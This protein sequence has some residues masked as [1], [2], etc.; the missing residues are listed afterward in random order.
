MS[1]TNKRIYRFGDFELKPSSRTLV[2]K[3]RPVPL[4]SKA[5]EVLVCLVVHHGDVVTKDQML[6][7]VWPNSFVD[8]GNLSQ[9]I[10][11]LR[12]ALA[13]SAGY[14]VT[15]PGRGYQF[16]AAVNEV[17]PE[18]ASAGIPSTSP[19]QDAFVVQTTRERAHLVM[20]ESD[21]EI[22]PP[23]PR[24]FLPGAARTSRKWLVMLGA[25]AVAAAAAIGLIAWHRASNVHPQSKSIVLADFGNRTGDGSFDAVL[26]QALQ[27]DLDQSP[28]LN[29]MSESGA[30]ATLQRMDRRPDTAFTPAVAREVCERSNRQAFVTSSIAQIG[31]HYLLTLEATDCITGNVL[32]AAKSEAPGKNDILAALDTAANTLRRGLGESTQSMER[33]QVPVAQATTSS[34]EAL[35]AYSTGEYLLGRMGEEQSETLPLF[36]QAVQ[37]D[38]NFAMAQMAVATAYNAMGETA[39]ASPYYQKAFDLSGH[40]SEKEKLYIQAHYYADDLQDLDKGIRGYQLWAT[41]YPGDWGP[42]LNIAILEGEL[43]Q[44]V[45]AVEAAE[46]ALQLDGTRGIIYSTLARAYMR[47][48]RFDDA[49]SIAERALALGKDS[50]GIHFILFEIGFLA[51]DE[52]G[53][54]RE[55]QWSEGKQVEP[56]FLTVQAL[57]SASRG[58][59]KD[60]EDLF[61]RAVTEA[62]TQHM[63]EVAERIRM[64]EAATELAL[65]ER[66]MAR[67]TLDQ[68]SEHGRVDPRFLPLQAMLGDP[69]TA[70]RLLST[71]GSVPH[72]S[73]LL[74]HVYLPQLRAVVAAQH[75]M[76]NEAIVSLNPATPYELAVDFGVITQRAEAYS[77]AAQPKN[78]AAQYRNILAHQ[79]VDAI[80]PLYPLAW[81]GLARADAQAKNFSDSRAAYERFLSLWEHADRDNHLLLAAQQE[82]AALPRQ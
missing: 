32:A 78:T 56:E 9:H 81:L 76:P 7:M 71:Q 36:K 27:I 37:L 19:A 48:N 25:F 64:Q 62:E 57:A 29:V 5:F 65:G 33:F 46:H 41:T 10:F 80:S 21:R 74:T 68:I 30:L 73:E 31:Q 82:Y 44:G 47:V 20:E 34:F 26:R 6:K 59:Y 51:N 70:E 14:I 43:G 63:P 35:K 69:G 55:T 15:I 45:P 13:D 18:L 42:W 49:K 52:E 60:A 2:R 12:K 77:Q 22:H 58:R 16:I 11:A 38:P 53:M 3:G 54:T 67:K 66:G 79:G 24:A 72:P 75:N 17:Q 61:H 4:G 40:V 8:E 28:S 23:P 39:L 50:D 1:L